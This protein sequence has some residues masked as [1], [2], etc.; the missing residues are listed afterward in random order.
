MVLYLIL[1]IV[2]SCMVSVLMRISSKYCKSNS[3]LTMMSYVMCSALGWMHSGAAQLFPAAEG[4]PLALMLGIIAGVLYL[5]SFLLLQWNIA[6][7]GVVLSSTFMKLGVLVPTIL[8]L[9]V[10]HEQPQPWQIAGIVLSAAAILLMQS[11]KSE[12]KLHFGALTALLLIGGAGNAMS[13][14]YEEIGPALLKEQF[15]LYIFLFA[16]ILNI[17]LCILKKELISPWTVLF[18]LVIGIPNYY[19]TRFLLLSLNK[20]DAVIAYPSYSVGGI[21]LVTLIGVICFHEKLEKRKLLSM[22]LIAM[23]LVLLNLR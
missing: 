8:S 1:A 22:L 23:S 11:G 4:L 20:I 13:K 6:Q 16:L 18:G 9:T 21:V 19:C 5:G 7:N 3:S 17:I 10:F 2:S 14:I 15:L 12:R